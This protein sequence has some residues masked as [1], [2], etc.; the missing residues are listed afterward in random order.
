ME[1]HAYTFGGLSEIYEAFM[2]DMAGAAEI[3]A[4]KL[5]GRSPQGMNSTGEADLRNYYDMIAQMQER[6]LRPALEKLL[7]VMAIS[8]WGYVP[9]DLEIV[10]EPIMRGIFIPRNRS[11]YENH[12]RREKNYEEDHAVCSGPLPVLHCHRC[13]ACG[14]CCDGSYG[15]GK[16]AAEMTAEELY[17]AGENAFLAEDYGKALEYFQLA[18]DLGNAKG[19]RYIGSMYAYGTGVDRDYGKALEYYQRAADQGEASG[20]FSIG[21]LYYFGNGVEQDY[22]KAAES[23]QKAADLGDA[24]AAVNLAYMYEH[25]EGVE[26]DYDLAQ[27]Y[28]LKAVDLGDSYAYAGLGDLYRGGKGVE[29][30]YAKAVEYYTLAADQGV[31]AGMFGLGE[32]CYEGK[33]LEKDPGK[34]AEWYRKALE[35]GYVPRE[36]DQAHLKDVLGDEYTQK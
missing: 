4:T 35:A 5:F 7:P 9:E 14:N 28:Y 6:V 11:G 1:T 23:F 3:P 32:C 25:G 31:P 26:Q 22:G 2:M 16:P 29:Q 13:G 8:C 27:K 18:A 20:L 17:Q 33:G 15:G 12:R 30:D 24:S 36:E 21:L 19:L 10:F 34:A